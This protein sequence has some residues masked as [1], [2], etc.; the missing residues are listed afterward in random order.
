V[1]RKDVRVLEPGCQLDLTLEAFGTQRGRQLGM[2]HLQGDRTLVANVLGQIDRSHAATAE[3]A[4][5]PVSIRQ[6][7]LK[8]LPQVSHSRP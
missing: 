7:T 2:E 6:A 5:D 1:D 3:L 4:L 8:L